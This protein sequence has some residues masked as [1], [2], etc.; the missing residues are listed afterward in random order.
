MTARL[1]GLALIGLGGLVFATAV[2]AALFDLPV[3]VYGGVAL[4]GLVAIGAAGLWLRRRVVVH[5]DDLGYRVR[6]VRGVG[7]AAATWTEVST[8]ATT[9]VAGQP[10]AVLQLEDGRT[11]TIPVGA[12]EGDREQFIRDLQAHLQR[13]HGLRSL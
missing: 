9:F 7:T 2:A 12:L 4:L 11:T 8:V 3:W 6:M 10:C 1:L 5:L 13:G